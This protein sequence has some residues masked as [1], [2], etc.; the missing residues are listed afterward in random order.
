M[1]PLTTLR[2]AAGGTA[3]ELCRSGSVIHRAPEMAPLDGRSRKTFL[4]IFKNDADFRNFAKNFRKRNADAKDA[5]SHN[6]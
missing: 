1:R 4:Q 3:A 5:F 6:F 2:A